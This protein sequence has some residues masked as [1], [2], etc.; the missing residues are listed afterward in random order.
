MSDL[1]LCEA[2]LQ[3]GLELQVHNAVT[4]LPALYKA[5]G[6]QAHRALAASL[7]YSARPDN[8]CLWLC[9]TAATSVA[10]AC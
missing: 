2:M 8:S 6:S 9:V 10:T 7:R 5:H 4:R 1:Q 3:G